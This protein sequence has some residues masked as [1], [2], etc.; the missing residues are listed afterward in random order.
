[1]TITTSTAKCFDGKSSTTLFILGINGGRNCVAR[2]SFTTGTGGANSVSWSLTNNYDSGYGTMPPLRWYIGTSDSSHIDAG[3]DKTTYH[4]DVTA[5]Y[6]GGSYIFSG[7][8][9]V[10]LLPNTT[11]YLWIY[12]N[13][14]AYGFYNLGNKQ[15]VTLETYG[16]A[17]L[18]YIDS[19]KGFE[20]YQIYIDN[21]T[22][23]E[24]YM[25]YISNGSKFELFTG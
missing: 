18:V 4:G 8:A 14:T 24:L 2:Y 22:K 25:P 9:D 20:A 5:T 10:V 15:T 13:T 21:G 11:Y 23:W 16:A 19:G 17:G 3:A 1:M 7:E 12:P 6:Y